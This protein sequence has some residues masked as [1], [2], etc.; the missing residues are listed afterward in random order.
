MNN[1]NAYNNLYY[2]CLIQTFY[3]LLQNKIK[4]LKNS[5]ALMLQSPDWLELLLKAHFTDTHCQSET[6][7]DVEYLH[8]NSFK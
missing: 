3:I 8:L 5:I 1:I 4:M 6:R 7:S 2:F